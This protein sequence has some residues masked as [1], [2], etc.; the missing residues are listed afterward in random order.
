[1]DRLTDKVCVVTGGASG[2][3]RETAL[4]YLREGATVHALDRDGH[5]L[6]LLERQHPHSRLCIAEIDVTD[7]EAVKD[8][9]AG[10]Q[11][12]D[13][14]F[15][16]AG[17]VAVGN[18]QTCTTED[19]QRSLDLNVT[20]VFLMMRAAIDL[21]LPQKGGSI[22]NVA[23]VISSIG[24]AP[25]RFA[26]GATK[27]AVI[28]MTISVARDY[29]SANIR[30]NAI[31]PSAIETPSMTARIE[32]MPDSAAARHGFSSRQPLGR[33]GTPAEIA[34]LAVYLAS[35]LSGFMTGSQLVIDGGAKL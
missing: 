26:Y 23:S 14:Q 9:H 29:A 2:I 28:G 4:A 25:D 3:G 18:I 1:M 33:M 5:E 11:H 19:W 20:S 30:C 32:A 10:L 13:V 21:M 6:A 8:F 17:M 31:C 16:C 7:P 22:I 27:A 15:N 34:E 12:L 35:D 24:A